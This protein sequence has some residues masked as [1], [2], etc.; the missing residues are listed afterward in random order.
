LA[1][2]E[3]VDL[4]LAA[5]LPEELLTSHLDLATV[6]YKAMKQCCGSEIQNKFF[7][8]PGSQTHIFESL[9]TIF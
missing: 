3:A 5:D 8:D 4:D 1:P 7:P 9:V 6:S 2:A